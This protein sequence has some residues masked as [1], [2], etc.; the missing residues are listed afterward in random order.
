[1]LNATIFAL[2]TGS[3]AHSPLITVSNL[4]FSSYACTFSYLFSSAIHSASKM[5]SFLADHTTFRNIIGT[6]I[7]LESKSY[8]NQVFEDSLNE[9][10]T[11]VIIQ[12]CLFIN[13]VSTNGN[14]G[15]IQISMTSSSVEISNT[16][17]TDCQSQ[18]NGGA[19]YIISKEFSLN[20]CCIKSCS[21]DEYDAFYYSNPNY[22]HEDE[23]KLTYVYSIT[24]SKSST[25]AIY[26]DSAHPV[27]KNNNVTS[28]KRNTIRSIFEFK[29]FESIDLQY[30]SFVSCTGKAII[31]FEE[32]SGEF[33]NCNFDDNLA[34]NVIYF[35]RR[36]GS[37]K[38]NSCC[39][40]NDNSKAYSNKYCFFTDCVFDHP[41]DQDKFPNK[42][43]TLRCTFN[44]KYTTNDI[45]IQKM[46][47]IGC[48]ALI[49]NPSSE[50]TP[51]DSS[52][53]TETSSSLN[54]ALYIVILVALIAV[55]CILA[56]FV[57]RWWK[58]RR[59]KDYMLTMYAQV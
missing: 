45:D 51:D 19:F 16:G 31:F 2:T 3:L 12:S 14:G 46:S 22:A 56:F 5:K 11:K 42:D 8:S 52:S 1:M 40:M 7:F 33:K 30:N 59:S 38:F 55:I 41:F 32:F 44:S 39:F 36:D 54:S 48:W 28:I 4:H 53:E 25:S 47:K 26:F 24:P 13:C 43:A 15:G 29:D 50:P 21:A 49:S 18:S 23:I 58:N 37:T 35:E 17:I 27:Y 9:K 20:Q 6:G 34:N 10:S 57:I